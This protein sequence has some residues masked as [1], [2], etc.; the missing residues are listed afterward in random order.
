MNAAYESLEK[1]NDG[2]VRFVIDIEGT[3]NDAAFAKC[4]ATKPPDF[5]NYK[6]KSGL[7]V[8]GILSTAAAMLFS[9]EWW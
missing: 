8:S 5:G 6:E 3:L 9:C 4:E 7:T 1:G 2:A